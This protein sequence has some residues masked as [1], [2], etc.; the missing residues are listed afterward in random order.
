[1]KIINFLNSF[2]GINKKHNVVDAD[3]LIK[4]IYQNMNGFSISHSS[5][6]RKQY[7]KDIAYRITKT[8]CT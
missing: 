7:K 4:Q 6:H 5:Q 3:N 1:M 2:F 8:L